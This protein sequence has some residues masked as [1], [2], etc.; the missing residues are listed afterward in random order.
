MF[1]PLLIY[2]TTMK[3]LATSDLHGLLPIIHDT[4]DVFVI[5]G[6]WSPLQIQFDIYAMYHW[7]DSDFIPWLKSIHAKHIVIIA[8]NHDMVCESYQFDKQF[9]DMLSSYNLKQRVHYLCRSSVKINK[10]KFYGMPD[11]DGYSQWAFS[12]CTNYSFDPDTDILITHQPPKCD[13]VGYVRQYRKDFGSIALYNSI[14]CS[15]LTLNI[16]G[17]IH[18]GDHNEHFIVNK[19]GETRVYNVAMLDEDYKPAYSV[20]SIIL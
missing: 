1:M 16:C 10:Y 18:T 17:H 6:D 7:I 5:A 20:T 4:C 3:I 12:N 14:A 19:Q 11:T 9:K 13:N 15:H 2:G 8:G